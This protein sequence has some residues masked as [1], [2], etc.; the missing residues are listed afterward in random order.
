MTIHKKKKCVLTTKIQVVSLFN[1]C[2]DQE[3]FSFNLWKRI[4]LFPYFLLITKYNYLKNQLN[5]T[6]KCQKHNN[7]IPICDIYIVKLA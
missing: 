4:Q 5:N 2:K 7:L 6:S 3:P 1:Y